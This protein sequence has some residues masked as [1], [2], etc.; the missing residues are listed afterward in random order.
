[1]T[2]IETEAVI[3]GFMACVSDALASGEGVELRGFGTFHV[4][5]RRPRK[6]RNPRT[7]EEIPVAARYMPM[8]RPSRSLRDRVDTAVKNSLE[9]ETGLSDA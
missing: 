6:A 3:N 5:R 4:Q 7:N 8:F 1:M 9:S 2:R